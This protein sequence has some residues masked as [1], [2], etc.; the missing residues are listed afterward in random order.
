MSEYGTNQIKVSKLPT[1]NAM[2]Y[3]KSQDD[4]I[5]YLNIVLEENNPAEFI[6]S[7]IMVAEN[8][9]VD[10][11]SLYKALRDNSNPRFETISRVLNALQL[12]LVVAPINS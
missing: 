1:F 8:L 2:D 10:C 12:K 11:E 5:L 3:L 6:H 4:V 7:L 9:G